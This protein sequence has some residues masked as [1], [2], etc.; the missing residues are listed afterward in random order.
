MIDIDKEM[1]EPGIKRLLD[2]IEGTDTLKSI[3]QL[4]ILATK[5]YSY[6]M[7]KLGDAIVEAVS[8]L[9]CTLC[10]HFVRCEFQCLKESSKE[11]EKNE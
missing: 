1:N 4:N 6:G 10:Q 9:E 5:A 3:D 2:A 7:P 8:A 11:K